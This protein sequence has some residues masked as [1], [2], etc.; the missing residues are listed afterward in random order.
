MVRI[1][2]QNERRAQ[3]PHRPRRSKAKT[4]PLKD[5]LPL[6]FKNHENA[7]EGQ[8]GAMAFIPKIK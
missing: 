8:N 1:S 3:S 6:G 5:N 4:G 7:L 2:K